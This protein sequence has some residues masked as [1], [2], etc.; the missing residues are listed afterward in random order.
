MKAYGK[1]IA[2]KEVTLET[3]TATGI[4]LAEESSDKVYEVVSIGSGVREFEVGDRLIL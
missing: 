1:F 3:K 4:Y 2:A